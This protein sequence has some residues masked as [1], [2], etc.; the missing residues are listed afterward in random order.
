M[1]TRE[2]HLFCTNMSNE[3][4]IFIN[5][6]SSLYINKYTIDF[7]FEIIKYG[8]KRKK[9]IIPLSGKYNGQKIKTTLSNSKMNGEIKVIE[10]NGNAVEKMFL[11]DV[12]RSKQC[13]LYD[14]D[15]NCISFG[16]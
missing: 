9:C 15:G 1:L 7:T 6:D 14:N 3:V 12:K 8:K 10:K 5:S 4:S 13:N 2:E 16:E 11:K